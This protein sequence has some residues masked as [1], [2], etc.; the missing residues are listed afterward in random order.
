MIGHGA[1][2]L[3]AAL[4]LAGSGA[5]Q[6]QNV[7]ESVVHLHARAQVR[8]GPNASNFVDSHATGS[9]VSADGLVLT[10]YH[11]LSDMGDFNDQTLTIRGHVGGPSQPGVVATVVDASRTLDLML[12][13]LLPAPEPYPIL[14]L[15][16]AIDHDV[17][18]PVHTAG[19]AK[20]PDGS[21]HW[22]QSKRGL[23]GTY[24]HLWAT[25]FSFDDGQSGGPIFNDAG[26]L[27]AVVKGQQGGTGYVIPIEFADS[28]LAQ[29]R[30]R[31]LRKQI[32]GF[33]HL[34][35]KFTWTGEVDR[36]GAERKI[37]IS[38]EKDIA[39]EPHVGSLDLK[40]TPIGRRGGPE[41]RITS[42]PEKNVKLTAKS[43]LDGGYF[44]VDGLFDRIELLRE[45][46]R[47]TR[48]VEVQ[49]DLVPTLSSGEVL[50]RKRITI[51][52]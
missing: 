47:F 38:Y 9:V 15:G 24:G 8:S 46:L 10:V 3:V 43:G 25:G 52:Y 31:E 42:F 27:L 26:K 48:I 28:L 50:R 12:L 5:A 18:T 16:S 17:G 49:I 29:I 41:E 30:L 40:V 19:F 21:F 11:L 14:A 44:E 36:T 22:R 7:R 23:T 34:R 35:K 1:R 2:L 32:S 37:V 6:A 51:E 4:I 13:K 33:E 45:E 39:G 20:G